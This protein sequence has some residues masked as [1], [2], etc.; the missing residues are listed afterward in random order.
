VDWDDLP[1]WQRDNQFIRTHYRPASNSLLRSFHS[2]TYLHNESVNIYTHLLPSLLVLSLL[3]VAPHLSP[4]TNANHLL[5]HFVPTATS[6][7]TFFFGFFLAGFIACLFT[8]ATYH[9]ISNHSHTFASHGNKADYVGIVLLITGSFIPSIYYG[10]LPHPHLS[11]IYWGMIS[12]LALACIVVSVT[13]KFRTPAYR[14]IRAGMFVGIGLSAVFPVLHGLYLYG[15]AQMD[16]QIGLRWLVAQGTLYILGAGIYAMRVPE[17]LRPGGF[18]VWGSS[19][20]VFHCLVVVAGVC[21][22]VG[23]VRAAEYSHL[24]VK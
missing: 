12:T 19:H 22:F 9:T 20:Q 18:D 2:L 6:T 16:K 10:F 24:S 5:H 14:P 3:L 17:K 13:P 1:A 7:D 11:A 15:V 4:S 21:H 23:L 8:S